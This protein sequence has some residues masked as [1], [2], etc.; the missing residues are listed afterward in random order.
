M[1]PFIVENGDSSWHISLVQEQLIS[2][3]L[4]ARVK[5]IFYYQH[6]ARMVYTCASTS[7]HYA[8]H[9]AMEPLMEQYPLEQLLS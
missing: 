6:L 1:S 5:N 9:T 4:K 2:A 8:T 7:S 3:R